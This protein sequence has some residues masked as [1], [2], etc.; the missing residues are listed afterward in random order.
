MRIYVPD[1]RVVSEERTLSVHGL[2]PWVIAVSC[3]KHTKKR[4]ILICFGVMRFILFIFVLDLKASH[5]A[6]A[7]LMLVF[8]VD[9]VIF[10]SPSS[11][12]ALSQSI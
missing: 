2:K 8:V 6:L 1:I 10:L 5:S 3:N 9:V 4:F 11:F 12:C 7:S